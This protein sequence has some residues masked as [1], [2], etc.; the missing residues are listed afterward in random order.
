MLDF[1]SLLSI[2]RKSLSCWLREEEI[3]LLFGKYSLYALKD[4]INT[5][6]TTP[7][8]VTTNLFTPTGA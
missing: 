8:P 4:K 5:Y 7:V 1:Q 2:R 3:Y 6:K